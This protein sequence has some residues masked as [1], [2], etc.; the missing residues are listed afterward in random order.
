[1]LIFFWKLLALSGQSSW[2][3]FSSGKN[4]HF[5]GHFWGYLCNFM[6]FLTKICW[7]FKR[8]LVRKFPPKKPCYLVVLHNVHP[9]IRIW[10]STSDNHDH[11]Q[12][13]RSGYGL[14]S[15]SGSGS[16]SRKIS[17]SRSA[18]VTR[19]IADYPWIWN[20][21]ADQMIVF[22]K[23]N[24]HTLEFLSCLALDFGF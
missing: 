8:S 23:R 21:S 3:W 17:G 9:W 6:H 15:G 4:W 14:G 5:S 18:S 16:E 20:L 10:I 12:D 11:Y 13:L 7:D 22:W 2:C 24:Q 1:M 19:K